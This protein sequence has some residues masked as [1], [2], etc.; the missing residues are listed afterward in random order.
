MMKIYADIKS[1][2]CYKLALLCSL[3]RIKHQWVTIDILK[4]ETQ[5]PEFLA[6]N[7]NGKIP[8]LELADGSCISE[9]NAILNYLAEGTVLLPTEAKKRALTLQWQFFEQYSHEPFIAVARYINIYLGLPEARKQEYKDLQAGGHKA[10][11]VM[12]KQLKETDYLVGSQLT[13]AD[14]SLY[15][16]TH[17]AFEGGFD[18]SIYPAITAWMKRIQDE[19]LYISMDD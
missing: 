7:S 11:A 9:S 13:I 16:Y 12:D 2:N 5:T 4:G 14:I 10:L 19:P 17:V 3:L 6:K 18:L 8:L 1:G 15:A